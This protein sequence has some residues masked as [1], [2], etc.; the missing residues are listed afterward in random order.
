MLPSLGHR[1]SIWQCCFNI[2]WCLL[3]CW[4]TWTISWS[5]K[6]SCSWQICQVPLVQTR[7]LP[8]SS[9][10]LPL[11]SCAVTF[12]AGKPTVP[13]VGWLGLFRWAMLHCSVNLGMDRSRHIHAASWGSGIQ[14]LPQCFARN[15]QLQVEL[16]NNTVVYRKE[17]LL[18][19]AWNLAARICLLCDDLKFDI[20]SDGWIS[21]SFPNM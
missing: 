2:P 5:W 8:Q 14:P 19:N 7:F 6:A 15:I 17:T 18:H 16:R 12:W 13:G 9:Q 3:V 11:S 10:F 4:P 21:P 1:A 20:G